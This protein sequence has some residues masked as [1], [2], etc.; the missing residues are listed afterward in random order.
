MYTFKKL[1][2]IQYEGFIKEFLSNDN[3]FH[4]L[5]YGDYNAN[6]E[7]YYSSGDN[8]PIDNDFD[9]TFID[10]DI[11]NTWSSTTNNNEALQT[12]NSNLYTNND[13]RNTES[14]T[15]NSTE[16]YSNEDMSGTSKDNNIYEEYNSSFSTTKF[17]IANE[18]NNF[19]TEYIVFRTEE[20][21]NETNTSNVSN[22][23]NGS[24]NPLTE[25]IK[26]I[27]MCYER[28]CT[29]ETQEGT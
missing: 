11:N 14:F 24:D 25:N 13:Y 26:H 22:E 1:A 27:V 2:S 16:N 20:N 5:N 15:E 29:S 28:V 12:T 9:N 8:S 17:D 7:D 19:T 3:N 6:S 18:V 10:N 21:D 23:L 4:N